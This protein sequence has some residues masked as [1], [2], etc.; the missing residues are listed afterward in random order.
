[1]THRPFFHPC[2]CLINEPV[3][4]V[5]TTLSPRAQTY[6]CAALHELYHGS[7]AQTALNLGYALRL[8]TSPS[9]AGYLTD[10]SIDTVEKAALHQHGHEAFFGNNPCVVL[11]L[12]PDAV[13]SGRLDAAI[14]D[15]RRTEAAERAAWA[16]G[17]AVAGRRGVVSGGSGGGAREDTGA[18][19]GAGAGARV[20]G[21]A[22]RRAPRAP[23]GACGGNRTRCA[24]A[25]AAIP[26][27]LSPAASPLSSSSFSSFSSSF[28]SSSYSTSFAVAA[29]GPRAGPTEVHV[30]L[31][32]RRNA[33]AQALS[34]AAMKASGHAGRARPT[35]VRSS[36]GGPSL[37]SL[38]LPPCFDRVCL[39]QCWHRLPPVDQTRTPPFDAFCSVFHFAPPPKKKM[40]QVA[41]GDTGLRRGV[42][43]VCEQRRF[44][45][46]RPYA[47]GG[48]LVTE[49]FGSGRVVGLPGGEVGRPFFLLPLLLLRL[50]TTTK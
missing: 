16:A 46:L 47:S 32:V 17:D 35:E 21:R 25:A 33:T 7:A 29:E 34:L 6:G 37:S 44:M 23:A 1:M 41:V 38:S 10:E 4:N 50:R 28:S 9:E 45:F 8:S 48:L 39:Q 18:S 36:K 2:S 49:D 22:H 19:A 5:T 15:L 27:A 26:A 42:F 20:A 43:D 3:I 12:K 30:F 31:V 11:K 40:H 13:G 14:A 24:L